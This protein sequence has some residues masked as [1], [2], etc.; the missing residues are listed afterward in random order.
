M[1]EPP[2]WGRGKGLP[3]GEMLR[4]PSG[5]PLPSTGRD[6]FCRPRKSPTA[7]PIRH[8]G[9]ARGKGVKVVCAILLK[10]YAPYSSF[11]SASTASACRLPKS[12]RR[13]P[14]DGGKKNSALHASG[15]AERKR[16]GT[17][18]GPQ[19][20]KAPPPAILKHRRPAFAHT[21]IAGASFAPPTAIVIDDWAWRR[22]QR[23]GIDLLT[24]EQNVLTPNPQFCLGR[25]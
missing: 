16:S 5:S 23:Y 6:P 3:L 18:S 17:S 8:R 2:S 9:E 22:N 4:T 12:G 7:S 11:G 25:V 1:S 13:L 20:E 15:R 19:S 14:G 21:R 24:N 10:A